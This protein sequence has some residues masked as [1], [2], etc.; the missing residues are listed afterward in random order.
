MHPIKNTSEAFLIV[1]FFIASF[2][3]LL[4]NIF[5][6]NASPMFGDTWALI[7]PSVS[8]GAFMPAFREF[9]YELLENFNILWSS[10]RSMGLPLMG[11]AVQSAPLFP[12][13]LSLIWVPDSV[14]WTLMPILRVML[15]GIGC[16]VI[17]RKVFRFSILPSIIFALMAGYNINIIRWINHPWQNGILAGI[18][19]LYFCCSIFQNVNEKRMTLALHCL[20]LI[21][22]VFAM[23]ACGFPEASA[24]A[25]IYA[26]FIFIGYLFSGEIRSN[27]PLVKIFVCI[28]ICHL[29][30]L[31][32]A[33]VQ[34]F[35]LLEFIDVS[36]AMAL[37]KNYISNT[38]RPDQTLPVLFGQFT[39]FWL[40]PGQQRYSYFYIGLFG[41]FFFILGFVHW[42]LAI[43]NKAL[44]VA[45]LSLMFLYIAKSFG[46]VPF[47]EYSFSV[48]PVL[49]Q[50]HFPQ[51]FT[52]LFYFGAAYFIALGCSSITFNSQDSVKKRTASVILISLSAVS[53]L[54]FAALSVEHFT[55]LEWHV[56]IAKIMSEETRHLLHFI[57][58]IAII[59]LIQ[60]INILSEYTSIF[61]KVSPPIFITSS[62]LILWLLLEIGNVVP[63]NHFPYSPS[64]QTRIAL[65]E[66]VDKS[67]LNRYELRGNSRTADH[68][69][70]G[71]ASVDNG[72][73]AI[74]PANQRTVKTQLFR[75]Q[76]G[77]YY[78]ID[79]AKTDWSWSLLS[80]NI[81]TV[82][83]TSRTTITW[84]NRG[85]DTGIQSKLVD[86]LNEVK[87][88]K[89]T[90]VYIQGTVSGYFK[91]FDNV[92]LLVNFKAKAQNLWV[93]A[94]IIS[95]SLGTRNSDRAELIT[96]WRI[97]I[98]DS[99]LTE[100][101]YQVKIRQSRS[102]SKGYSDT[103][104]FRL[105]FDNQFLTESQK[106]E[107]SK[108]PTISAES[109][110]SHSKDETQYVYFNNSALPRAYT[111]SSC[112]THPNNDEVIDYLK[113]S[114]SVING[115][116]SLLSESNE[117]IEFC[118]SF[119][120]TL[121]RVKINSDHGSK[122][123]LAK[124]NGPN[125]LALHDYHY[126]GW[127]AVD[128]ISGENLI[129]EKAN[130]L[131]R[132]IVLPENK[133]YQIQF[134][135][136]PWWLT[137]VYGLLLFAFLLMVFGWLWL[138]SFQKYRTG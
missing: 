91:S 69:S 117:V 98:P 49:A 3:Y 101:D 133:D 53:V 73:S 85:I 40:E 70:Y 15:I 47:I 22:S 119:Q 130:S 31:S 137:L 60:S 4:P 62:L 92:K 76:Y 104:S 125:L 103:E 121:N 99:W 46:L 97:R 79:Y 29:I 86:Q 88:A 94:N 115:N 63:K 54:I 129:I 106:R 108:R 19:Y 93:K 39:Y 23:I 35:S 102:E 113:A 38:F 136:R 71:I 26:L 90:P 25:A 13:N 37:R 110:L 48:I 132:A 87:I 27:T 58:G 134:V 36:E 109:L 42:C 118:N 7:D 28:I 122:V 81:T 68:V 11:N 64:D 67:G 95:Q 56:L 61:K 10:L 24:T 51:Y 44:G 20:G 96:K 128:L 65:N 112:Q 5:F 9:R 77:G 120:G 72:L 80:T 8:P 1:I 75:S 32:L 84:D 2:A 34:I 116:V 30:G 78:P 16:Y 33:A 21:I 12:L 66:A 105:I 41:L 18:W 50:S 55:T 107:L 124:V 43:K 57:I 45:S 114:N 59:L 126:P 17:S 14:Y 127:H 83:T 6:F 100:N 135:Y 138:N 111:A 74:Y 52:N 82:H 123:T 131:F 89:T